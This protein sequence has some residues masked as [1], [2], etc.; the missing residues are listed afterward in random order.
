VARVTLTFDNG[1][2]DVTPRVLDILARHGVRATFFVVGQSVASPEGCAAARRAHDDGHWI[3]NHTYRHETPLGLLGA[4]TACAEIERAQQAIGALAHPDKLFRPSGGGGHLDRRLLNRAA[5]DHLVAGAYSCVLWNNVPRDWEDPGGWV[6]Q[7]LRT[8]R[9]QDDSL[10][11]LHDIAD[12]CL[13]GLDGF[14]VRLSDHGHTLI[15]DPPVSCVPLRRGIVTGDLDRYV[16][17]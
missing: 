4:E 15:Q 11:V 14:L 13:D 7:A 12:A 1:P 5:R 9:D 2:S 17:A 8:A 16:S 6:D 3:G 10:V